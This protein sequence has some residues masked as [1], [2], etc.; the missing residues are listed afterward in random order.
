MLNSRGC[1][2][3]SHTW[4]MVPEGAQW[5][6]CHKGDSMTCDSW[7]QIFHAEQEKVQW[8]WTSSGKNLISVKGVLPVVMETYIL[9]ND[10]TYCTGLCSFLSAPEELTIMWTIKNKSGNAVLS[11]IKWKGRRLDTMF[12]LP[13]CEG[14]EP[15]PS[16]VGVKQSRGKEWAGPGHWRSRQAMASTHSVG[17][18]QGN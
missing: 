13:Q 4:A 17:L 1:R 6:L 3:C 11:D 18:C 9:L 12:F 5:P 16:T 2:F 8:F 14:I 10:T 15:P 7:K